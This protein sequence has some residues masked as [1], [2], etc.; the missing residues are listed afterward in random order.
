MGKAHV[1]RKE[2]SRKKVKRKLS[3]YEETTGILLFR[4]N[5]MK[6]TLKQNTLSNTWIKLRK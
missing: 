6:R 3:S 5:I 2:D 1:H 4:D